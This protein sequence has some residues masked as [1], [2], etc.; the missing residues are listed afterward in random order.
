V[1]FAAAQ[2]TMVSVPSMIMRLARAATRRAGE[3]VLDWR[4]GLTCLAPWVIIATVFLSALGGG[5]VLEAR[6]VVF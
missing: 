6:R 2:T 5:F 1:V 4:D 3:M